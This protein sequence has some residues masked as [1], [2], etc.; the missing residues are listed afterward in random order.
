M[1]DPQERAESLDSERWNAAIG[2]CSTT[3]MSATE[4]A[5]EQTQ[6]REFVDLDDLILTCS[7]VTKL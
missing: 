7:S 5:G 4:L 2:I 6:F 1:N 3:G